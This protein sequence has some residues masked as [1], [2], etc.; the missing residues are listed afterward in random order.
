M[1]AWREEEAGEYRR[2]E[3]TAWREEVTAWRE[4]TAGREEGDSMEGGGG[5]GVS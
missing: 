4:V 2:E 1:A 5:R 3:V